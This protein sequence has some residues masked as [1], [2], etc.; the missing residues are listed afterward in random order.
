[1]YLPFSHVT[2]ALEEGLAAGTSDRA[3]GSLKPGGLPLELVSGVS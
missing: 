2:M 1:M 3:D